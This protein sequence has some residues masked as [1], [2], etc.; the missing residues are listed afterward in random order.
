M[1]KL[2]KLAIRDLGRNKRRSALTLAAVALGL[3]L[4]VMT[5][6]LVEG[7]VQ[8]S[9]EN[10]IR[11]RTAHVQIRNGSYDRDKLTVK[12]EDLVEAPQALA[13][14][15]QSLAQVQAAMPVLWV[16]GILATGA[17]SLGVQ[18]YGIVPGAGVSAPFREA[19]VAGAFVTP[20][21]RSGILIGRRLAES[22]DLA[23]G[24]DVSLLV[25]TADGQP[26]EAVFTI[27]GL[28]DT[29]IPAYDETTILMPL[30]KAQAFART[31][32]RASAVLILL[33][34][35]EAAEEIAAALRAPGRAILT[36]RGLNET[37]LHAVEASEGVMFLMYLIVL[38]VVAV[39][40]ANTL[41]MAVFERTREMG[42][43]AALGIKGHEV[44]AMFVTE[45]GILALLGIALGLVLGSAGVYYLATQGIHI[46][47]VAKA[48]TA[49]VAYG[50][51][52]YGRFVPG[53]MAQLAVA[54][55]AITLLGSLYPAWFA[56]RME[57]IEALRA[58]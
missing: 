42:I 21:D 14:Q 26:D 1:Y 51:T 5:S 34:D 23:V 11:V 28:Y 38:A 37:I 35:K 40:I 4:L 12:W 27:R 45:A 15:V 22:L 55:L 3:A 13:E 2:W 49:D 52:I 50:D 19:L 18:V 53:A 57:P 6:G 31:G 10:Y 17:E 29:G 16:N 7:S 56:A 32:D 39:V 46:G 41:L 20:D 43:L 54:E 30:G 36:W 33:H 58:Q 25:D 48:A 24:S 9:I 8:G 44:I 47:E